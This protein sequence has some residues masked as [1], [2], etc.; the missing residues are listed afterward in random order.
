MN[1]NTQLTDDTIDLRELL[2]TLL[3]QWKL[4]VFCTVLALVCAATYLKV[5]KKT[6]SV[7]AKVQMIDNK[8]NGLAGLNSQLAALG[9]L[10][11]MSLGS[12]GNQQ[13]IQTEIEILQ[14]R[15]ILA[16]TIQ[17]LNL[18]I[19]IQPEQSL[20]NKLLSTD[21]FQTNYTI[22][23]VQVKNHKAKFSIHQFNIPKQYLDH[24]LILNFHGQSFSLISEKTGL[25]VFKGTVNQKAKPTTLQTTWAIDIT[26]HQPL[27]GRYIVQKQSTIA[28]TKAILEDFQAAELAKQTGIITINYEGTDKAHIM[29]VLNHILEIYQ[30]QNLA[31][32]S[33]EKEKSLT[34]LNQQLPQLKNNLEQAERKFNTFRETHGTI[35]IQQESALYLKQSVELETQK[36]QLEQKQAELAA[37]YTP[38]HPMMQEINAQIGVFNKKINELN[39]ALKKLPNTQSQYLQY[40]RDVQVQTQLYTSLL[41]TYQSLNLAKAG[42]TGNLRVLDYPVEPTKPIKPR[43]LIILILSMFV[44]GFIGV[45][46]GLMRNMLKTG[47]RNRDEIEQTIGVKTYAELSE[48]SKKSNASLQSLKTFIPTLTFKLQQRQHNVTLISSITPDQNQ[49]IIVQ[50]LALYL[51]QTGKKVLLVDSDLYRG[52]LDQLFNSSTKTGLFEY[53]RGQ[54]NLDQVI[55]N[56]TSPN[57]SLIGR[58]Q[59]SDEISISSHQTHMAQ[60]IQQVRAQYDYIILSAAPVLAT[61]D[62]LT[63]AQF[64]G[65]NLCLVQYAQ[66]QLKDI[67]LAKSYFEN[68][69]LEIDGLILDQVPAYQTKQYQYQ[70]N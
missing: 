36:V 45:L 15:S 64:T 48:I 3:T 30:E 38:Q 56:T 7:D 29:K 23:E 10:A 19:Q 22:D 44:G 46:I 49:S 42:E 18:D 17:D 59:S 4:I 28:A 63:L 8:Q 24:N 70:P 65:F 32:K 61:S 1:Q 51:S 20:L 34:F 14:S 6:Y 5:A 53:L 27:E 2:F 25:E 16:K 50:H 26:S 21:Q 67:E 40:Y 37:Q 41:G 57:L 55:V 13:S 52:Q 60:L 33:A 35:D 68:A 69:G 11:G 58:G 66:T 9:S 47:V 43:K 54:A 39:G 31:T 12:L 62:S